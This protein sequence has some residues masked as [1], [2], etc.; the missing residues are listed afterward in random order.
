MWGREWSVAAGRSGTGMRA[1]Q[2]ELRRVQLIQH[3]GSAPVDVRRATKVAW[4]WLRRRAPEPLRDR[5]PAVPGTLAV[6][7]V[8]SR[9]GVR[10]AAAV[11][12]R[13]AGPRA[14]SGL[15]PQLFQPVSTTAYLSCA[16]TPAE[17]P[18]FRARLR[19]AAGTHPGASGTASARTH[20]PARPHTR[21]RR[22][23]HVH[24]RRISAR[25]RPRRREMGR[26]VSLAQPPSPS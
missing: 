24:P 25:S 2:G 11:E 12:P 13:A 7:S 21:A 4:R 3:P 23:S 15:R 14:V 26:L 17:D 20:P 18:R 10:L 5:T 22:D 8:N 19:A 9:A 16:G 6:Q 1:P